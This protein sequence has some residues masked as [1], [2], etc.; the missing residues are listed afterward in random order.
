[1]EKY[2]WGFKENWRDFL[3]HSR[4]KLS[5]KYF[6]GDMCFVYHEDDGETAYIFE[7]TDEL[8]DWLERT[9][10]DGCHY[11]SSDLETSMDEFKIWK[12]V[13]ESH[14]K[15]FPSLYKD[16]KRTS[17]VVGEETYYRTPV[18]ICVEQTIVVSA[19]SY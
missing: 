1:M 4:R 15:K 5:F 19:S 3:D 18:S 6:Y 9:F 8:D 11:E 10:W 16:A 7:K 13:S 17:L 14:V 2:T 12:L